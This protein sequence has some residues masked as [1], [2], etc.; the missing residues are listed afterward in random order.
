MVAQFVYE[1]KAV[2]RG[3]NVWVA[4][5]SKAVDS[6][7]ADVQ[8]RV[9]NVSPAEVSRGESLDRGAPA[10]VGGGRGGDVT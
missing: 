9:A 1:A 8:L 5:S 7:A 4:T 6:R 3:S 2:E 10:P